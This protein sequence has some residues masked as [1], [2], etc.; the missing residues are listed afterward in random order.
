MKAEDHFQAR[1][2]SGGDAAKAL[3]Y[4]GGHYSR[5]ADR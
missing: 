4:I 3:T 2:H 5:P 1:G